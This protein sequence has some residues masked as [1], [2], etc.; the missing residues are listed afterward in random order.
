MNFS[1]TQ[2]GKQGVQA[3]KVIG[4]NGKKGII[5]GQSTGGEGGGVDFGRER[6]AEGVA[7]ETERIKHKNEEWAKG[8]V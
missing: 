6:V 3:G 7:D 2:A 5:A 8:G 4:R 1:G